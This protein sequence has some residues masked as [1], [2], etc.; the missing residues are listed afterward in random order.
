MCIRD[1]AAGRQADH[2]TRIEEDIEEPFVH[3][4]AVDRRRRGNDDEAIPGSYM[5][6]LQDFG[7]HSEVLDPAVRAGADDRLIDPDVPDLT[8]PLCVGGKMGE[9]DLWL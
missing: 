5:S 3:R 6:P 8:D 1:R 9:G 2:A 4:L 7:S